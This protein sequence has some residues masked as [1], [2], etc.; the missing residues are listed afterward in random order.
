MG[1]AAANGGQIH[2][3]LEASLRSGLATM[4]PSFTTEPPGRCR[5]AGRVP[6][7]VG[8]ATEELEQLALA[9]P[10]LPRKLGVRMLAQRMLVLGLGLSDLRFCFNN[11]ADGFAD[12]PRPRRH[13]DSGQKT[14]LKRLNIHISAALSTRNWSPLITAMTDLAAC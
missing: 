14:I 13:E 7:A 5:W 8:I 11:Q 6:V 4:R 2:T 10:Q 3:H 9:V 12:R 1:S